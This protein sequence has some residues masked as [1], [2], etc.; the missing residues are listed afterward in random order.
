M[1]GSH[2]GGETFAGKF[3]PQSPHPASVFRRR[4]NNDAGLAF[5]AQLTSYFLDF[6]LG[7]DDRSRE[8][9]NI[10]LRDL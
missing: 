1:R 4:H 9:V 3:V 5:L 10:F 8:D 2:D 7:V 6:L